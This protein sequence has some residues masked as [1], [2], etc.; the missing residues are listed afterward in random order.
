M[1]FHPKKPKKEELMESVHDRLVRLKAE[2]SKPK[3]KIERYIFDP[4][5]QSLI[6]T[7]NP[8]KSIALIIKKIEHLERKISLGEGNYLGFFYDLKAMEQQFINQL[9]EIQRDDIDLPDDLWKRIKQRK[10]MIDSKFNK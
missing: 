2:E 8:E 9:Y 4:K 5:N 3:P 1:E 6:I 7:S 10:D